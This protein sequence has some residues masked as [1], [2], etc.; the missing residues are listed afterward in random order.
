[1]LRVTVSAVFSSLTLA[2]SQASCP[3]DAQGHS[4]PEAPA[5]RQVLPESAR[6]AP[7]GLRMPDRPGSFSPGGDPRGKLAIIAAGTRFQ[8][9]LKNSIDSGASQIGEVIEASLSSP[10][11]S[12]DVL[13]VPA[14]SIVSGQ[15]T[16][17]VSARRVQFAANGRVDIRFTELVTPDGRRFPLSASA[18][19]RQLPQEK[20][21]P[22]QGRAGG[23][24]YAGERARRRAQGLGSV[25]PGRAGASGA[26]LRKCSELKIA[27]GFPLSVQLDESLEIS[28]AERRPPQRP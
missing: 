10:L 19:M 28:G 5:Y 3:A 22:G 15:V 8:A 18:D 25:F 23:I 1:M 26:A 13:V 11:Y 7:P 14:G 4:Q 27:S 24:Q 16:N 6:A 2:L 17:V 21:R 20:R 9:V 12:N